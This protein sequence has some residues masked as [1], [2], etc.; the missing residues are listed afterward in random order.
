MLIL[1]NASM[2]CVRIRK[3]CSYF[4]VLR[5]Y[6]PHENSSMR[7]WLGQLL[8]INCTESETKSTNSTHCTMD[9]FQRESMQNNMDN[10]CP[11]LYHV[12]FTSCKFKHV[13]TNLSTFVCCV[14]YI[15]KRKSDNAH[16]QQ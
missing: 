7:L 5:L 1:F 3:S 11:A 15:C 10:C 12:V 4:A 9:S 8:Q 6:F 16:F 2:D 13:L 14:L